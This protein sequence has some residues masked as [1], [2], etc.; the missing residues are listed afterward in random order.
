MKKDSSSASGVQ[1]PQRKSDLTQD[2]ER[3]IPNKTTNK[4]KRKKKE[5]KP[6]KQKRHKKKKENEKDTDHSLDGRRLI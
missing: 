1:P 6:R 5:K 2:C 3:S 4:N